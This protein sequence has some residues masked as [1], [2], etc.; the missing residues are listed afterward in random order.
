MVN[1]YSGAYCTS[2]AAVEQLSRVMAVELGYSNVS[3]NCIAPGFIRTNM[4]GSDTNR[5][6]ILKRL[7]EL[8]P[9]HRIAEPDEIAAVVLFLAS[10]MASYV[11]G[12]TLY[13]DGGDTLTGYNVEEVAI[14]LPPKY[15]DLT[16]LP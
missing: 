12:A 3:V 16:V 1:P 15:R 9:L 6:G 14:T 8:V 7:A 10:D 11:N 4:L 5:E 13:V 2:K